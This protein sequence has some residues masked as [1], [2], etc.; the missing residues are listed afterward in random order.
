MNGTHF[1]SSPLGGILLSSDGTHLTGLR[2]TEQTPDE[3]KPCSL[4]IFEQTERWLDCF[5]SGRAPSFTPP[6]MIEASPFCRV[7]YEAILS[8]PFGQT[9]TYGEI[10]SLIERMSGRPSVLP[11]AVG[12]TIGRNPISL[13][14]PC[15]RVIGADGRLT[16]YAGGLWRKERLLALEGAV[17]SDGIVKGRRET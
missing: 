13:I 16:G 12:R 11:R 1:V 7:V 15:H 17:I 5:F 14:I 2:F 10:A 3:G 9:A 8:I 4:S 6:L